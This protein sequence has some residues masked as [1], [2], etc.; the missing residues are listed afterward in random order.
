M[1][2][3]RCPRAALDRP[4]PAPRTSSEER[5]VPSRVAAAAL[6]R[7][8][9]GRHPPQRG[10]IMMSDGSYSALGRGWNLRWPNTR[11]TSP[12]GRIPPTMDTEQTLDFWA[13]MAIGRPSIDI[14]EVISHRS[15]GSGSPA[16]TAGDDAGPRASSATSG[17]ARSTTV[18]RMSPSC[19]RDTVPAARSTRNRIGMRFPGVIEIT[20]VMRFP[21]VI[22]ITG[23]MRSPGPCDHRGHAM[24]GGDRGVAPPS[25]P[26]GDER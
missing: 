9:P 10:A 18:W 21:G 25:R 24:P 13:G 26:V 1:R 8:H 12:A 20:G 17:A 3:G 16:A 5:G 23:A 2:I 4:R 6:S 11:T 22:E 19:S 15:P 7:H 14:C